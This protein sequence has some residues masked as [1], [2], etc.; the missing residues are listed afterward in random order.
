MPVVDAS[1]VAAW[2][3]STD[4]AHVQS[5]AWIRGQIEAGAEFH[6][7]AVVLPEVAH[8]V[9][10]RGDDAATAIAI[11]GNMV[12]FRVV[13]VKVGLAMRAAR[14][15]ATERIRGCDAIY[16]ALAERLGT[17]LV[18]LDRQQRER[19]AA[20]VPTRQP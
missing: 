1:V 2:F 10:S 3:I 16:V 6:S 5:T 18:T 4:A 8:A 13:D 11:L 15:A 20:V 9:Q 19:G 7:P 17:E 12:G 14:I